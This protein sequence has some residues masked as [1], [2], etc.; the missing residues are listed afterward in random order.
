MLPTQK[1]YISHPSAKNGRDVVSLLKSAEEGSSVRLGLI[2]LD[3]G[4]ELGS[5]PACMMLEALL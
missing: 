5:Q 1:T 2:P 4:W 3:T